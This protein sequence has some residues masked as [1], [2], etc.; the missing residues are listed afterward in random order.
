MRA[1]TAASASSTRAAWPRARSAPR[2]ASTPAH[3]DIARRYG[4]DHL[5]HDGT[6]GNIWLHREIP[7]TD[8]AGCPDLVPNGLPYQQVID[9]ANAILKGENMSV[10]EVTEGLYQAK[11]N[12]GRNIFDSVIQTRNELKDRAADALYTAKGNDGRNLFDGVIQA[13]WDI[14]ELKTML[15]AQTAAIEALSQAMG[16]DPDQIAE[17]VKH[18]VADKLDSLH[19]T[20]KAED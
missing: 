17:A 2:H 1:T 10:A 9:K 3:A 14:A 12:D 20:I 16:A 6:R 5:W 18:A 13:R 8:H 19:I 7:G 11:G 15:T 4:W